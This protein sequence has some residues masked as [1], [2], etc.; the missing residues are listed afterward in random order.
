M[1]EALSGFQDLDKEKAIVGISGSLMATQKGTVRYELIS[2]D[3][4]TVILQAEGLYVPGLDGRLFE[5]QEYMH[6]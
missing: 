1:R 5:P 3:G 6:Q 4:D 2:N